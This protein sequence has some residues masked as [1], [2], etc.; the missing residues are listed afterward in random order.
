MRD[1]V[2]ALENIVHLSIGL[3]VC[4]LLCYSNHIFYGPN[5]HN[6]FSRHGHRIYLCRFQ[7]VIF[8]VVQ[9]IMFS[10]SILKMMVNNMKTSF[11]HS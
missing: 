4:K 9:N 3:T 1:S 8:Q 5:K 11:L 6:L 10:S 2:A 7:V